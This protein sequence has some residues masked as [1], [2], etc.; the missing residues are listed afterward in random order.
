MKVEIGQYREINKGALKASFTLVVHPEGLKLMDC[1]YFISGEKRWFTLP[2]K[3]IKYT[4]GRKTNYLP[5]VTYLNKTYMKDLEVAVLDLLK[6]T[7]PEQNYEKV[8]QANNTEQN[9]LSDYPLSSSGY[10]PF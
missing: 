9:F 1:K 4:D 5:I 2:Q 6:S 10:S 3:E 7:T 8:N